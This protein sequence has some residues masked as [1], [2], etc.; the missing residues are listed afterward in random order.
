[1]GMDMSKTATWTRLWVRVGDVNVQLSV[2]PGKTW[3]K[4]S[5]VSQYLYTQKIKKYLVHCTPYQY[6]KKT[7]KSESVQYDMT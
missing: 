5:E 2:Q 6:M 3:K 7:R 1:M 4:K